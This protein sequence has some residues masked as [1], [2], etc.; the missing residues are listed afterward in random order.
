MPEKVKVKYKG[1]TYNINKSYLGNL[2][3]YERTK[4]IKSIV[5]K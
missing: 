2:R 3:G 4:K 5:E 1:Q